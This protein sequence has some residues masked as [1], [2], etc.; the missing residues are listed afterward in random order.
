MTKI[1]KNANSHLPQNA[2]MSAE[3]F[4][5]DSRDPRI[6][7]YSFRFNSKLTSLVTLP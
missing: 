4:R 7:T 6:E 2:Q 1:Q 3:N 5:G